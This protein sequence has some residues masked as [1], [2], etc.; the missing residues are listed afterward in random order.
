M[1]RHYF[2]LTAYRP[3]SAYYELPL[4]KLLSQNTTL[5]IYRTLI[6]PS[7]ATRQKHGQ[8]PPKT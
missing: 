1:H 4:T 2:E 3:Y 8:W 6:E 7:L 5:K